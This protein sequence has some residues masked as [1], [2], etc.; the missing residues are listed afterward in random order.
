MSVDENSCKEA[1]EL[2]R[3]V[4]QMQSEDRI[5][6]RAEASSEMGGVGGPALKR[7][8]KFYRMLRRT[9]AVFELSFFTISPIDYVQNNRAF[10]S[11]AAI[12]IF[13]AQYGGPKWQGPGGS[14]ILLP[15]LNSSMPDSGVLGSVQELRDTHAGKSVIQA[16]S[17]RLAFQ[18]LGRTWCWSVFECWCSSVGVRVLVF[19]CFGGVRVRTRSP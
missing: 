10:A 7:S 12:V 4:F 14:S 16:Y 17:K 3:D 13:P 1:T 9:R 18:T 15:D 2:V 8:I 11:L 19:E 5:V 6:R